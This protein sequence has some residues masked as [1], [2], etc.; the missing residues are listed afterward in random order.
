MLRR[1]SN[2]YI[3]LFLHYQTLNLTLTSCAISSTPPPLN[4]SHYLYPRSTFVLFSQPPASTSKPSLFLKAILE[5]IAKREGW[6]LEGLRVSKLNAKRAMYGSVRNKEFGARLGKTEIVFK[7]F[8]QVPKW[9]K[10]ESLGKRNWS[11]FECLVKEAGSNA[12]LD[13]FKIEGPLELYAAGDDDNFTLN[14]PSNTS[15]PGLKQILVS[16]GMTLE[17]EGAEEI[18]V[19][20]TPAPNGPPYGNAFTDL[21]SKL[22]SCL[23]SL[24]IHV[25]GP[26]FV[27]V[28][29]THNPN[30]TIETNFLSGDTIELLPDKCY[31]GNVHRKQSSVFDSLSRGATLLEK[32]VK[33][34]FGGRNDRKTGFGLKIRIKPSIVV[35][36]QMELERNITGNDT[37]WSTLG[38]WRTRPNAERVW[39][40]VVAGIREGWLLKPLTVRKFRPYAE[41]D[42]LSWS[43]LMSNLSFTKFPSVIVP[44]EHLTLDVKW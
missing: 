10:F 41:V 19:F 6:D 32:A 25:R 40:E 14:L 12:V 44:P 35:R 13:G 3:F 17:V 42:S 30:S 28:Y 7:V 2:L 37:Q 16:E 34:F 1:S 27:T 9:T 29:R 18:T 20:H 38:E 8:D 4:V 21:R 11:D 23:S 24:P 15:V 31:T 36:F 33:S 43:S 22:H 39:F 26:A 5:S